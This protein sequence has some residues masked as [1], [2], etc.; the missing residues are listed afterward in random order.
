MLGLLGAAWR[1]NGARLVGGVSSTQHLF[2]SGGGRRSAVPT[3]PNEG[4][5]GPAATYFNLMSEA[6][7]IIMI[8]ILAF[9][10][11][12]FTPSKG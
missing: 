6:E 10:A 1:K 11:N 9:I 4:A 12:G 7:I 3:V 5:K 2:I 8:L